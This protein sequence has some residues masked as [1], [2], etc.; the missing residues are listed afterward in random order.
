MAVGRES[1]THPAFGIRDRTNGGM[2]YVFPPYE[3]QQTSEFF[4][5]VSNL[6]PPNKNELFINKFLDN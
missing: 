1:E 5:N 6:H 3:L 2:H 4:G